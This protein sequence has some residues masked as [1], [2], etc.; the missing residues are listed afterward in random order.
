M[1]D[2][3]CFL[4]RLVIGTVFSSIMGAASISFLG[5]ERWWSPVPGL[6]LGSTLGILGAMY[7]DGVP[8]PA[9]VLACLALAVGGS[10]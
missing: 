10:M 7:P 9:V 2:S 1:G 8:D 6:A 4:G 3:V 5:E